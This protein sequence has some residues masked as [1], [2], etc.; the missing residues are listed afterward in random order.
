MLVRVLSLHKA[1][2]ELVQEQAFIAYLEAGGAHGASERVSPETHRLT[3][4]SDAIMKCC[5]QLSV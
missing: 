2:V 3:L 1:G 5:V 4:Y